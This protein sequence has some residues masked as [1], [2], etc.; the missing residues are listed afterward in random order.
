[1]LHEQPGQTPFQRAAT[2][3]HLDHCDGEEDGHGVVA[4][5]LDLQRGTHPLLEPHA[6]RM[7]QRE[8]RRR[9]GG[10]HDRAQQ[11]SLGQAQTEHPR[12]EG[13]RD[14]SGKQHADGGQ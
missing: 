9:I 4:A 6:M 12:G 11:E 10:A 14:A 13:A 7:Q 2:A 5:R 1:L 8:H 3:D